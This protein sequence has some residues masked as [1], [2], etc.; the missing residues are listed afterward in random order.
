MK[1][2][3]HQGATGRSCRWTRQQTC[4]NP[5]HRHRQVQPPPPTSLQSLS[6]PHHQHP[7]PPQQFRRC[8]Y[9]Q[10]LHL[11]MS[12]MML[13]MKMTSCSARCSRKKHVLQPSR[14]P[15]QRCRSQGSHALHRASKREK[16]GNQL[17]APPRRRHPPHRHQISLQPPQQGKSLLP[18]RK[19]NRGGKWLGSGHPRPNSGW[20]G[21]PARGCS[22][23][24]TRRRHSSRQSGVVTTRS[25]KSRC[26]T[27]CKMTRP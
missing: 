11:K 18:L 1:G 2:D 23:P 22:S 16:V 9:R 24:T 17:Q 14:G 7:P 8:S 13:R 26:A 4:Q 27:S 21:T 20:K 5:P 25:G 3:G 10:Q 15:K 12:C 6:P 19:I